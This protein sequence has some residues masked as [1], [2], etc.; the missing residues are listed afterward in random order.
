MIMQCHHTSVS[1]LPVADSMG[2][3]FLG[4]TRKCVGATGFASWNAIHYV[5]EKNEDKFSDDNHGETNGDLEL[6]YTSKTIRQ[7]R[8]NLFNLCIFIDDVGRYLLAED[9]G[10]NCRLLLS[11][12]RS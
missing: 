7:L 9:F 6:V 12:R 5:W 1:S 2:K 8:G 11:L 4:M 3:G 10:E